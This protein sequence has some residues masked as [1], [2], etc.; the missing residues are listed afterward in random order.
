MASALSFFMHVVN[1][2]YDFSFRKFFMHVVKCA[3]EMTSVLS[4]FLYVCCVNRKYELVEH[5]VYS[6]DTL[7]FAKKAPFFYVFIYIAF[8]F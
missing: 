8:I 2:T 6:L 5:G 1:C 4:L 7:S 3:Y